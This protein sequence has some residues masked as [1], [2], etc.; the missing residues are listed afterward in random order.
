MEEHVIHPKVGLSTEAVKESARKFLVE[1]LKEFMMIKYRKYTRV[2]FSLIF[3]PSEFCIAAYRNEGSKGFF[4]K[5]YIKSH[6]KSRNELR[7]HLN[8]DNI[9]ICTKLST[10]ESLIEVFNIF[11]GQLHFSYDDAC[12]TICI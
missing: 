8:S 12:R 4:A 10:L 11:G 5:C 3:I 2:K 6:K 1:N 7:I 9:E